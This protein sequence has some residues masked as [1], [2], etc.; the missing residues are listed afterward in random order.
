[1][2]KGQIRAAR[3]LL[4]W[5]QEDLSRF[6]GVSL[7]TIRRIEPGDG[8]IQASDD[9]RQK[10]NSALSKAGIIFIGNDETSS[11]GGFGVR[12]DKYDESSRLNFVL[13]KIDDAEQAI[14]AALASARP[15]DPTVEL[16]EAAATLDRAAELVAGN[17]R[18]VVEVDE[19]LKK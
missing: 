5:S 10:I 11:L 9:V 14:K 15:N 17:L 2:E 12:L 8:P 18:Y 19:M 13:S 7:T 16:K 1:M 3:A 4:G 6:S